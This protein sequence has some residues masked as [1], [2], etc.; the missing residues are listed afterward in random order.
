[1]MTEILTKARHKSL[2]IEPLAFNVPNEWKR[3]TTKNS[4]VIQALYH[5]SNGILFAISKERMFRIHLG[6]SIGAIILGTLTRFDLMQWVATA[7]CLGLIVALEL[8]N[9]A[10]ER[11]TDLMTNYS[12][13]HLARE[14]KD[15][16]AG[17][18]LFSIVLGIAVFSAI[19]ISNCIQKQLI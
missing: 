8:V 14:A 1:M 5:A 17:A 3:Q 18:V 2:T 4:C 10:V 19:V 11:V 15:V 6:L 7:L 12:Y 16:A 9:T 13:H